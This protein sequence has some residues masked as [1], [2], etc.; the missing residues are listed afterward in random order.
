MIETRNDFS[1]VYDKAQFLKL[2]AALGGY[3]RLQEE[4]CAVFMD[5]LKP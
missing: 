3:A 2:Y 1:H 4:M 5:S